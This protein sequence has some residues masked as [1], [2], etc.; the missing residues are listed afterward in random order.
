M[1]VGL[2]I[3]LCQV[4]RIE[5]ALLRHPGRFAARLYTAA[6]RGYCEAR[7]YPAQHYAAR[8]AAKEALLKA[9]KVPPGLSWHEIEVRQDEDGAPRLWLSGRAKD[10]ADRL[11]V[12]RLH[13]SLTH[14]GDSAAA[15]VIAEAA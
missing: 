15:F 8:F 11:G 12:A 14:S 4:S 7:A 13:L 2:G 10:A 1:I 6:E 9:L 5:R 3:D